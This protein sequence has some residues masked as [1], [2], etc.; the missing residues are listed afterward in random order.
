MLSQRKI[1]FLE[2]KLQQLDKKTIYV[3][4]R[5]ISGMFFFER[6]IVSSLF[7]DIELKNL[8]FS[9]QN[10]R[11]EC[12]SCV[13]R[14]PRRVWG[15]IVCFWKI[16]FSNCFQAFFGPLAEKIWQGCQNFILLVQR[17]T[18][19]KMSSFCIVY[20]CG[21]FL[22]ILR[23]NWNIFGLL[24]VIFCKD[25]EKEFYLSRKTFSAEIFR[26]KNTFLSFLGF[27]TKKLGLL[28]KNFETFFQ[29]CI[30]SVKRKN[31]GNFLFRNFLFHYFVRNLTKENSYFYQKVT[32]KVV[33][34]ALFDSGRQFE[35]KSF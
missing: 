12:Q 17:N 4:R 28:E 31:S 35:E 13:L 15:I 20:Q 34:F 6:N 1:D 9:T 8:A 10:F 25:H 29:K 30:W 27:E 19:K 18:L 22:H 14:F 2:W 23:N 21:K 32:N 16:T 33:N 3:S 26:T 5:C 11:W 7:Q 24:T